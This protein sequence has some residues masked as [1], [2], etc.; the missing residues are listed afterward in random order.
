MHEGNLLVI[1]NALLKQ[2]DA[3]KFLL[4]QGIAFRGHDEVE[5]NLHQL[6][7]ILSRDD[8][9]VRRLCL[10]STISSAQSCEFNVSLS[11]LIMRASAKLFHV[12]NRE[13]FLAN[14]EIVHHSHMFSFVNYS[15]Y[16]IYVTRSWKTYLLGTS[17]FFEK[18]WIKSFKNIFQINFL[19]IWIT[20]LM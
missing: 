3:V 12:I 16:S 9:D 5:G 11:H 7:V 2:L 6:L 18:T 4:N 1:K 17:K 14:T 13:Y 8:N 20:W 15:R 10:G 19:H